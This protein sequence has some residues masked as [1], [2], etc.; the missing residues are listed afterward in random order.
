MHPLCSKTNFVPTFSR[1]C[2]VMII[3]ELKD[4]TEKINKGNELLK[5]P[6]FKLEKKIKN[7]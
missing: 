5:I 3:T 4:E 2:R 6:I 7:D 1:A